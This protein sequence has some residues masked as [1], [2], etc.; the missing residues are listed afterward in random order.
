MLRWSGLAR[1][2]LALVAF[3]TVAA[4]AALA[5][6]PESRLDVVLRRDRLIVATF[7]TAPPFCF[8]DERGQLVGFDIDIARLIARGMFGDENKI[9][10]VTVNSEG[11]WPAVL[12]GRA[13][14]GIASTTVY[15]DRAA[16][17]AFTQPYID[18]GIGILVRRDANVSNLAEL[19]NARI[20][21]ANLSNPQMAERARRIFPN[22]RTLTFDTAS[23]LFL[24]V[25]SGQA[26]AMQMDLPVLQWYASN[27][28]DLA[29]LDEPLGSLQN[30]AIFMR[31]GDFTWWLYLDTVVQELRFGSRYDE[32]SAIYRKWFGRDPPPQRFYVNRRPG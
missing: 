24:A 23:A 17:V 25:R 18:S 13:D 5:Q 26:Q 3:L 19:N 31:P 15:P 4:P 7:S 14:F 20:T 22:A 27:H 6:Q 30:N 10:F 16:R 28:Q 1:A 2:A 9:E 12:S 32:Y 29:V 21:V 11:R 8:T